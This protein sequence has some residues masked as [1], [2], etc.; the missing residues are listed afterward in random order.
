MNGGR[1]W[2][3]RLNAARDGFLLAGSLADGVFDAGDALEPF[4]TNFGIVTD[5]TRGP[6]GAL[7]ITSYGSDTIFRVAPVPEPGTW[8]LM[9]FGLAITAIG[10]SRRHAR[11]SSAKH[12]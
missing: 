10:L 2:L 8:A 12:T 11:E 6:D 7:Y 1:L 9:V 5:L 4:G 3:L